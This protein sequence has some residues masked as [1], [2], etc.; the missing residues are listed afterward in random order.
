MIRL[1]LGCVWHT[2]KGKKQQKSSAV[3]ELRKNCIGTITNSESD[4]FF[5]GETCKTISVAERRSY[6]LSFK[7]LEKRNSNVP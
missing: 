2:D 3:Q 4:L 1:K 6:V 5:R 7:K